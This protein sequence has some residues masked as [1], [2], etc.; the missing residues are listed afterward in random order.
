MRDIPQ[1]KKVSEAA[2]GFLTKDTKPQQQTS[3]SLFSGS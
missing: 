3:K 2:G 1:E